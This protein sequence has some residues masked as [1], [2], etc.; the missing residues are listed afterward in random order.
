M[1]TTITITETTTQDAASVYEQDGAW[2]VADGDGNQIT[3]GLRSEDEALRVAR[4][5]IARR[6]DAAT[7]ENDHDDE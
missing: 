2:A 4:R 3:C 6:A 5:W 1:A 7:T